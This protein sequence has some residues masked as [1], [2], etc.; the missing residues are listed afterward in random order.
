M[1]SGTHFPPRGKCVPDTIYFVPDTIYLISSTPINVTAASDSKTIAATTMRLVVF[2]DDAVIAA[3]GS[4]WLSGCGVNFFC[5][6]A[7]LGAGAGSGAGRG[8]SGL[9]GSILPR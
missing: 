2:C 5:T 3:V 1:V 7:G 9:P 8:A 6:G 4:G